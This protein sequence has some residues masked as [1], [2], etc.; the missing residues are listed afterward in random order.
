MVK[1]ETPKSP[2]RNQRVGF[3]DIQYN[4]IYRK[5]VNSQPTMAYYAPKQL[6]KILVNN[7]QVC[8]AY[9]QGHGCYKRIVHKVPF[10]L[11]R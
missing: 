1:I 11:F 9:L 4:L 2:H 10:C 8:V 7:V 5:L 6:W 3:F